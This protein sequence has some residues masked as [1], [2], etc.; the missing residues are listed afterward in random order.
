MAES[1]TATKTDLSNADQADMTIKSYC[2]WAAGAG[3]IPLPYV[4]LAA[5]IG[6]QM[7][8]LNDLSKLYDT[9]F[10]ENAGKSAVSA[11]LVT[12]IPSGYAGAAASSVKMIPGI[13]TL[14]GAAVVPGA[15]AAAT[16]AIGKVFKQHFESGGTMLTFD[17]EKMREHFQAEFDSAK[18]SSRKTTSS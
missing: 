8:M 18:S 17:A 9:P 5:I 11:L 15:A 14:L 1:S 13:G 3:L 6:V 12:A 4:D 2:G 7:K 10:K 16:Y